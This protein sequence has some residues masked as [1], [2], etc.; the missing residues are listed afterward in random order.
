[1]RGYLRMAGVRVLHMNATKWDSAEAIRA[2][3]VFAEEIPE[4]EGIVMV[5]YAPYTAGGGKVLWVKRHKPRLP[6]PKNTSS[7]V[8][9]GKP[10]MPA[11]V[12][13]QS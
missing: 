2:Y 8:T 13:R 3:T 12:R 1:M 7:A 9:T 10:S 11:S 6:R 4:L 5:Q